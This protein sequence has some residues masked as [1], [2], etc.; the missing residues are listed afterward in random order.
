MYCKYGLKTHENVSDS[1]SERSF[2]GGNLAQPSLQGQWVM[3]KIGE[4]GFGLL[5]STAGVKPFRGPPDVV[6]LYCCCNLLQTGAL[7]VLRS[8]RP[9][10]MRIFVGQGERLSTS[11]SFGSITE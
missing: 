1:K 4:M 9:V 10:I 3:G 11:T 8:L 7:Y 2:Q 6:L 5:H